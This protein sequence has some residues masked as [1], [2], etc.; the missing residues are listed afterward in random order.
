[1]MSD[2][3]I[4]DEPDEQSAGVPLLGMAK[5]QA[6]EE[7]RQKRW[8]TDRESAREEAESGVLPQV[9]ITSHIDASIV[10]R[11]LGSERARPEGSNPSADAAPEPSIEDVEVGANDAD[12][13]DVASDNGDVDGND[14]NNNN[15]V[16]NTD[17]PANA[18]GSL[19]PAREIDDPF[20]D[21]VRSSSSDD[22]DLADFDDFDE[23]EGFD[24]EAVEIED[25][26]VD[27]V[28]QSVI[29]E[30]EAE[31]ERAADERD[32][33]EL[34]EIQRQEQEARERSS[35]NE[36]SLDGATEAA[37]SYYV[38]ITRNPPPMTDEATRI[39]E[40]RPMVR[41]AHAPG[42][43]VAPGTSKPEPMSLGDGPSAN[44]KIPTALMNTIRAVAVQALASS[45]F[46]LS[47]TQRKQ[48]RGHVGSKVFD[49]MT[50]KAQRDAWLD[51]INKKFANNRLTVAFLA[52]QANLDIEGL[53]ET[54]AM[55]VDQLRCV[56]PVLR[57]L[58]TNTARLDA[59]LASERKTRELNAEMVQTLRGLEIAASFMVAWTTLEGSRGVAETPPGKLKVLNGTT[60]V[61]RDRIQAM[62]KQ[63]I[64]KIKRETGQ[65]M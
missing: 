7:E 33:Q 10:A 53:D 52:A 4:F 29:A 56:D 57:E 64:N 23:P 19:T 62:T 24:G 35:L 45:T 27:E 50:E 3:S 51:Y 8:A 17:R 55:I 30:L 11:A 65:P 61:M 49:E 20:G 13:V 2:M 28:D 63:E 36:S 54:T 1:M 12:A 44:V 9:D 47:P 5:L 34:Q 21:L 58:H 43:D 22:D 42:D 16:P 15:G 59:V 37:R 60:R 40:D 32:E 26:D 31:E 46:E 38:D 6:E 14:N 48:A 39:D 41:A 18:P 25:D